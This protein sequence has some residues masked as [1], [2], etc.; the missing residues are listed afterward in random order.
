MSNSPET[1]SNENLVV[2][3]KEQL[4]NDMKEA[5]LQKMRDRAKALLMEV[6]IGSFGDHDMI[7]LSGLGIDVRTF[8]LD[9]FIKEAK[10]LKEEFENE[11]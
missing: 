9:C 6:V 5:M 3:E 11:S 4:Y 10:I 2:V 7:V 8:M 1:D